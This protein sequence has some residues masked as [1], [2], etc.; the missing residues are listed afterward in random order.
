M[1][2][3]PFF[4]TFFAL[5]SMAFIPLVLGFALKSQSVYNPISDKSHRFDY[6]VREDMFAGFSGD[7]AAFQR[8][9]KLCED[10]LRANPNHAEALV[11]HG[12]GVWFL[13]G[14][15]FQTGDFQRGMALSDSGMSQMDRGVNLDSNNVA[16]RIP[17]GAAILA[18]APYIQEPYGSMLMRKGVADY[19]HVLKIQQSYFSTLPVHSRGELLGAM[20]DTYR[21]LGETGKARIYF[22]RITK[23]LPNSEYANLSA[24]WLKLD[25][26]NSKDIKLKPVTC[27]GCHVDN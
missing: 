22:T 20:A 19:E 6:L 9:M 1:N 11:W 21:R 10:S 23:E 14:H 27:I 4:R 13:S 2:S 18:A 17:R 16:V 3:K 24:S 15:A 7:T 8:A 26:M 12:T 25:N 5:G